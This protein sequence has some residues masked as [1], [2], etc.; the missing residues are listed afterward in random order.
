MP[1]AAKKKAPKKAAPSYSVSGIPCPITGEDIRFIELAGGKWMA[2]TSLWTST[3]F[4]SKK[5]LADALTAKV[6]KV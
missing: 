6:L 5:E 2:T 1:K 4:G 3:I